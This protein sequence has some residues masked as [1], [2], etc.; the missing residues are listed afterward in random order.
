VSLSAQLSSLRQLIQLQIVEPYFLDTYW[1]AALDFYRTEVDYGGFVRKATGGDLTFGHPIPFLHDDDVRLFLTGTAEKVDVTSGG[2]QIGAVPLF[3]RFVSGF[4]S[5]LRLTLNWDTRNNRLFPSKGFTQSGSVERT[6]PEPLSTF[7]YTRYTGISRWYFPLP[8]RFVFKVQ[9]QV[10][11]ITG[12]DVPISELYFVGGINSVRGYALR[13]ISPTVPVAVNG[14]DPQSSTFPFQIGGNKQ[15][16]LNSELEF[17]IFEKLGVRGVVFYD[18]GNAFGVN[19]NFFESKE[20]ELPLGLFQ[21]LGFGFRWF[22]PL[23]PLRFEW[24][25]PLTRRPEDQGILFE[26]TIGNSF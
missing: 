1:T 10:G 17:P 15:L 8:W 18:M 5:S 9:G 11:Y 13:T 26:F 23:G 14:R 12:H 20:K 21:S 16:V 25:I 3:G 22:S 7:D 24:G 4:T 2:S 6:L 19:E